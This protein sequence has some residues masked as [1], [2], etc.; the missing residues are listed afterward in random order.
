MAIDV[1][2]QIS[3]EVVGARFTENATADREPMAVLV[4]RNVPSDCFVKVRGWW[5]VYGVTKVF[6][7]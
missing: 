3:P 4:A 6:T 1:S 5:F 2:K 7:V